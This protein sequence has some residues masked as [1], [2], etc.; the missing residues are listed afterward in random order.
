MIKPATYTEFQPLKEILVGSAFSPTNF[1]N[2]KDHEARDLL[3][4]VF[5][6][7]NED[8]EVLVD[9]LKSSG[10]IVHRPSNLFNWSQM[11]SINLPWL[12]SEFPNHPL[13]PRDVLGVFGS[14]I[15]E[16]YTGDGGRMFENLAYQEVSRDLYDRGMRWI[17]MPMP[18]VTTKKI[19]Y[20]ENNQIL[21]HSANIIKCGKDLFH[22]MSGNKDPI[23]GRGT[24]YGL[25]WLKKELNDEFTW[26]EIPVGGHC[27]GKIAL[28]KPGV[29][30]TW[31]KKWIP[32]KLKNWD[33]IEVNNETDI[34]AEFKNMRK[35][36]F[37]KDFIEQWFSH[38][39]GFV[40]ETVFDVNVLSLSE[41]AV[42]CTGVNKDAFRR[43]EKQGITPIYWKFRHQYFWDGGI[44]CLTQDLVRK[45]PQENYFE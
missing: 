45:G 10:I 15:V 11:Q 33:I 5:D 31:N 6:E 21:Y 4:R 16:Q 14:T 19:P 12:A 20:N 38:W 23:K 29:L 24:E 36:R 17:S 13:M 42:I 43:M 35:K 9:L 40:D 18:K 2:I 27:D 41:E 3:K 34:P 25:N 44:H 26:N 37:Y 28:L 22:S 7:T 8:I 39:I 30:M 32:E 1:D